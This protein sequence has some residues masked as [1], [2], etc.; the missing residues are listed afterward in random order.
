MGYCVGVPSACRSPSC[1]G[2]GVLFHPF[3][4]GNNLL[5]CGA[6]RRFCGCSCGSPR[7]R[8]G[9]INVIVTAKPALALFV[10]SIAAGKFDPAIFMENLGRRA[11]PT[12]HANRVHH[13]RARVTGTAPWSSGRAK[14]ARDVGRATSSASSRCSCCLISLRAAMPRADGRLAT[15]VAG[16]LE[17]AMA[18]RREH[19]EPGV[20]C[21]FA[22]RDRAERVQA[23]P[24]RV[25][26][27]RARTER[28]AHRHRA[29]LGRHH[30][31]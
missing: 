12:W 28:S 30:A 7:R 9:R 13:D 20:C 31:A 10:L 18:C 14:Y 17:H 15:V 1:S 25:R 29:H 11:G 6:R 4:S 27:S 26:C 16:I 23:A 8:K 3:E 22:M 21:R 24:G 5:S 19:R 2:A